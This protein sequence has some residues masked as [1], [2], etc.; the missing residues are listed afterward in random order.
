[1]GNLKRDYL[2][3][4]EK[5]FYMVT[6]AYIQMIQ[7][8]RMLDNKSIGVDVWDDW[9]NR[10]MITPSMQRSLKM[11]HT[12]LK[13]FIYELEENLSDTQ[14][15]KLQKGIRKFDYKIIDDY[16]LSKL[17][18]NLEDHLNYAVFERDKLDPILQ[19]VA[20]VRCVG[21]TCHYEKCPLFKALDD[22]ETP[23]V[24][25]EPN[26]PYAANLDTFSDDDL[27]NIQR[28]KDIVNGRHSLTKEFVR[29]V[30]YDDTNANVVEKSIRNCGSSSKKHSSKNKQRARGKGHKKNRK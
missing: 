19:D 1:M 2:N 28:M 13:K 23:Y 15:E 11:A 22:I 8:E 3:V 18:R 12:Y 26:C 6:K 17:T 21:C 25:E 5:N 4:E 10:G 29:K 16:M 7:G 30:E 9:N 20:A 24:G 14:N 27:K